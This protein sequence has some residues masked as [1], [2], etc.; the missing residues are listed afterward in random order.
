MYSISSLSN[1]ELS[2]SLVF[3]VIVD[4]IESSIYNKNKDLTKK[5]TNSR[6]RSQSIFSLKPGKDYELIPLI[7]IINNDKL[8]INQSTIKQEID[9]EHII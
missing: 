6:L 1:K 4:N 3:A 7:S 8:D 2:S 9:S 5:L